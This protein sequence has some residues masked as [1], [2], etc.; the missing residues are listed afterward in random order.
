M[1]IKRGCFTIRIEKIKETKN[2]GK[3]KTR[4]INFEGIHGSGKQP[5]LGI[6]T[7]T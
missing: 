3:M 1:T 4:F 6:F 5:V 7:I 2:G